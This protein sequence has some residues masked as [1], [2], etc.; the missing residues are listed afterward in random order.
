MNLP[1]SSLA[2]VGGIPPF[3]RS[4]KIEQNGGILFFDFAVLF[5]DAVS[6]Y[7]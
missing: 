1:D 5:G 6:D 4:A 7:F 2:L 3:C